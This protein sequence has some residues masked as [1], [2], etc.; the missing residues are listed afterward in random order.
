MKLGGYSSKS[1]MV[2]LIVIA[3]QFSIGISNLTTYC[4]IMKVKSRYAILV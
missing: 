1:S 2:L 4:L 3:D